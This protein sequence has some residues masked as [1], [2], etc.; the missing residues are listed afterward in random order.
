MRTRFHLQLHRDVNAESI[1]AQFQDGVLNVTIPKTE[2]ARRR[3]IEVGGG[4]GGGAQQIGGS[5]G[6]A[7]QGKGGSAEKESSAKPQ[8]KG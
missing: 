6:G 1:Q 5:G 4:Q 8:K 7:Q 3:R 2:R